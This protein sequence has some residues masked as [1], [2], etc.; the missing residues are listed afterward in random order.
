MT[1]TE[2]AQ[3]FEVAGRRQ[4][5]PRRTGEGLDNHGGDRAGPVQRD[6]PF[7]IIRQLGPM[8]WAS[9]AEGVL[10]KIMGVTEMIDAGQ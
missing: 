6:E 1:I 2:F 8:L 4:Q 9:D 3:P 5:H 7:E 10:L